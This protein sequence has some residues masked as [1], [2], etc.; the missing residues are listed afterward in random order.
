MKRPGARAEGLNQS[1]RDKHDRATAL[2]SG[3]GQCT[4]LAN[5]SECGTAGCAATI[6]ALCSA[7]NKSGG[8]VV[9]LGPGTYRVG[10]VDG[11]YGD[12]QIVLDG[13]VGVSLVGAFPSTPTPSTS[14]PSTLT[15]IRSSIGS[16]TT[17]E[18]QGL[19]AGVSIGGATNVTVAGLDFTM[20]R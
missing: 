9:R 5:P 10:T 1:H 13:L 18:L 16:R 15:P 3:G 4:G 2:S 14:T 8:G 11:A 20:R 7:C 17:L 19:S 6:N 12:H